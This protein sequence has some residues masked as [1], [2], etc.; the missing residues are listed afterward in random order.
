VDVPEHLPNVAKRVLAEVKAA[1]GY[2]EAHYDNSGR[3]REPVLRLLPIANEVG[4]VLLGTNEAL[5]KKCCDEEPVLAQRRKGA[6][7]TLRTR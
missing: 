4:E 3:R 5:H 6:K 7:K 1:V 2:S